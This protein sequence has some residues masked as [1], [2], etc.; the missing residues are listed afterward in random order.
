M[1]WSLPSAQARPCQ[2][3]AGALGWV[4]FGVSGADSSGV[5]SPEPL[6]SVSAEDLHK[7][8]NGMGM[9]DVTPPTLKSMEVACVLD[10]TS[11]ITSGVVESYDESVDAEAWH[12]GMVRHATLMAP[13]GSSTVVASD[14]FHLG[15]RRSYGAGMGPHLTR[16]STWLWRWHGPSSDSDVDVAVELMW[17]PM[18]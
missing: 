7:G 15:C 9:P 11:A 13:D 3:M 6:E 17:A 5:F 16:M 1:A 12:E 8:L 10:L 2:S 4:Q 18:D 14:W